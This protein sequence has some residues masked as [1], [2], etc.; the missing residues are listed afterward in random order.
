MVPGGTSITKAVYPNPRRW[1]AWRPTARNALHSWAGPGTIVL[2]DDFDGPP[3]DE[4]YGR[5]TAAERYRVLH[6]A[7]RELLDCLRDEYDVERLEGRALDDDLVGDFQVDTVVRLVPAPLGA[8]T[9]TIAFTRFPGLAV[10]L[11]RWYVEWYP[12]CGCDACDERP[13]DVVERVNS[14][15]AA[16]V[17]GRFTET[18]GL[19]PRPWLQHTFEG[20]SSSRRRLDWTEA[21]RLGAPTTLRW[22]PWQRR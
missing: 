14:R 8:G 7:A 21:H 11:G 2:V 18:L 1:T 20:E 15:V 5:V 16:L 4:A 19:R 22:E 10:R 12:G 9:L 13:D 17:A 3:P 6:T